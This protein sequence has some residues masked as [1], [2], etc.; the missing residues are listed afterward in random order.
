MNSLHLRE[1][2][3]VYMRLCMGISDEIKDMTITI[4]ETA[5]SEIKVMIYK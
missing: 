2:G 4:D 1:C 3:N 5:I